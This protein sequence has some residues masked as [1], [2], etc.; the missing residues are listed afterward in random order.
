MKIAIIGGGSAGM[1]C[2]HL[3]CREHDVTVYEKAPI[4]GGHIR[5]LNG[6]VLGTGIPKSITLEAGAT[7][8]HYL[9]S[10]T[11]RKLLK[12]L[13]VPFYISCPNYTSSLCLSNGQYYALQSLYTFKQ[14]GL[15]NFIKE[16][17]RNLLLFFPEI[18]KFW[19]RMFFL[20]QRKMQSM[21]MED[22]ID[23][24][25]EVVQKWMRSSIML[26]LSIP[27]K[28]TLELP[29]EWLKAIFFRLIIPLWGTPKNGMYEYIDKITTVDQNHLNYYCN[30]QIESV[31]RDSQGVTLIFSDKTQ[32][33]FDKVIFATPPSQAFNLLEKPTEHEK[34]CFFNW[35]ERSFQVT[36]HTDK[37]LY[38][39]SAKI[40]PSPFDLF[41]KS[42][43]DFGYNTYL[44]YIYRIKGP[45]AYSFAY[46]LDDR[47]QKSAIITHVN[48]VVPII[49][50]QS[51]LH[52]KDILLANGENNTFYIG[53]YL[54][55]GH[56]EYAA[57]TAAQVAFQ[58]GG[59][60]I[61]S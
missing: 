36:S 58:L 4:L 7:A 22:C 30:V 20:S 25:S 50:N 56:Q 21:N 12:E 46:N 3:L 49:N 47:I 18:V 40:S 24:I 55:Y 60:N 17:Q 43:G 5:T 16:S 19:G 9:S 54:G 51:I 32:Q 31:K 1:I 8:F 14:Y 13:N 26:G 61:V 45:I 33:Y 28:D 39:P 15:I 34:K 10:P 59:R 27:Y 52:N 2:A 53:A 29:S 6:N 23:N 44:N 38:L 37:T 42:N 48:H 57:K 41:E 35:R 11:L